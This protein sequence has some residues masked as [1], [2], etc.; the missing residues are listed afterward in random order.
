VFS[1][2]TSDVK[3]QVERKFAKFSNQ[4]KMQSNLLKAKGPSWSLTLP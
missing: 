4:I 1:L 2:W 3:G